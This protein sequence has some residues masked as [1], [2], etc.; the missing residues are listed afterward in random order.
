MDFF[1]CHS[2]SSPFNPG[3]HQKCWMDLPKKWNRCGKI[4]GFLMGFPPFSN[5]IMFGRSWLFDGFFSIQ[6][7]L[8]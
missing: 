2:I 5:G 7:G 6:Y 8:D 1:E 3:G 4:I